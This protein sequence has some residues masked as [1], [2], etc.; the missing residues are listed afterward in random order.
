MTRIDPEIELAKMLHKFT[1]QTFIEHI[2]EDPDF[3]NEQ[4]LHSFCAT[5]LNEHEINLVKAIGLVHFDGNREAQLVVN[6][7]C[8]LLID[9]LNKGE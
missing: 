7:F 2:R 6:D 9:I 1:A 3:I 4:L 5:F 8:G